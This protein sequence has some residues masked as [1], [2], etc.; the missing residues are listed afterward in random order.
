MQNALTSDQ[1]TKWKS[2]PNYAFLVV[3]PMM[4]FTLLVENETMQTPYTFYTSHAKSQIYNGF[5]CA[6]LGS[7]LPTIACLHLVRFLPWRWKKETDHRAGSVPCTETRRR[8]GQQLSDPERSRLLRREV[9]RVLT[10]TGGP[11]AAGPTCQQQLR[12]NFQRQRIR[13]LVA[14]RSLGAA[15]FSLVTASLAAPCLVG[16]PAVFSLRARFFVTM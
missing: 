7:A 14:A 15:G 8:A 11:H 10:L 2:P 3:G 1:Q 13:L 6:W 12:S 9:R 4:H 16:P 5:A